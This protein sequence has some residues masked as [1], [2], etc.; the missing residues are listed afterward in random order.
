M[1]LRTL[2]KLG[3]K[4]AGIYVLVDSLFAI[5]GFVDAPNGF[6]FVCR[7][8]YRVRFSFA[9]GSGG[10]RALRFQDCDG[11]SPRMR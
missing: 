2:T 11:F 10:K 9:L 5:P 7:L 8:R 4:S 3:L 1:D 6:P